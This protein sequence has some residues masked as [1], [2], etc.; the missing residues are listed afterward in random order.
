MHIAVASD[1]AGYAYKQA[2]KVHLAEAGYRV[3]DFGCE[4]SEAC[5]YPDYIR[6]AAEAVARGDV[7]RAVVLGGS[8]NGEAMVANRVLGVRCA[9]CWNEQTARWARS[10]NDANCLAI[11][12][13]TIDRET[14]LQ[15]LDVWLETA[16]EGGRHERRVRKIDR[17]APT[18]QEEE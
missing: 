2:I 12:E 11:G 14:A 18:V 4:C 10:H 15:V 3:T 5:D 17:P 8:G 16:F 7:D 9:L 1:H 6:P 13:R